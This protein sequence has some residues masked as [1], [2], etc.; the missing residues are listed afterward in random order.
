MKNRVFTNIA[1]RTI[2]LEVVY[3]QAVEIPYLKKKSEA[4]TKSYFIKNQ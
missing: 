3:Q 4:D 2:R 1:K